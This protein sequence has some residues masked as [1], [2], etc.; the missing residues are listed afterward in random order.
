MTWF[1]TYRPLA[2][3][4]VQENHELLLR[5]RERAQQNYALLQ[6]AMEILQHFISTLASDAHPGRPSREDPV[7]SLEPLRS[8][9]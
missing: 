1:I 2:A 6:Q 3:A 5:V 8:S 9:S 7:A 4:L